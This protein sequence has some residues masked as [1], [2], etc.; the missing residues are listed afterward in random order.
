MSEGPE[1]GVGT[2]APP[3]ATDATSGSAGAASAAATGGAS[4]EASLWGDAWRQLRRKPMFVISALLIMLFMTMAA[5]PGLFTDVSPHACSLSRSLERPSADAWF[6]YDVQGCDYYARTIY[7]ARASIVVGVT[8]TAIA[9][10]VA[11]VLGS[12]AGY[13]RGWLDAVIARIT[14]VVFAL[15]T[16]LGGIV[17]LS[18]LPSR[19]IPQVTL[20]ISLLGWPTMLRLM[21]STVLSVS[22]VEYVQSAR[23]L[24]AGDLRIIARHVLPNAITP[25]MVYAT[26]YVGIII[27]AEATLTFLGVGLQLPAISW[28]L[29]ISSAQSRLLQAPHLLFFPGLFL[30]VTV[31]AFILMGD[32]LRDALDPKLR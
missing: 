11:V 23:A 2:E 31:F 10:L 12:L 9:T 1:A 19:G 28:G 24:G 26:I 15:P 16:L 18:V 30:S 29:A 14:D 3:A 32:A 25:V 4:V 17:I 5:F 13:Y 20:V 7:G 27:V 22:Q 6:G 8:V 21:R